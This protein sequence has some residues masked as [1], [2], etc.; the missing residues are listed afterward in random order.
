MKARIAP[1]AHAAVH[2]A[3]LAAAALAS[4]PALSACG[5]DRVP[6]QSDDG[7]G[8]G[9]D[10]DGGGDDDG[11]DDGTTTPPDMANEL[12]SFI[13]GEVRVTSYDGDADDLLTA[14]LGR[15]G[16][17]G[18]APLP[19]DP[20]SPTAAELRRLAIYSN[21]RALV[22]MSANGGYGRFWGPNVDLDGNDTLGEGKIAGTEYLAF[23][24]DGTGTRNATLLVQI[25]DSLDPDHPC[26]VTATSSGSRGVYG[27]ISAAGEWGLKRGC[28]VAYTDKGTGNGGHELMTDTVT[29]IDGALS[30]RGDAGTTSLFGAAL[31]ADELAAFNADSPYRYAYKH[32][33]SQQNPEAS[34]GLYTL[35]AVQFATWA[36]NEA[37]GA[38][39]ESGDGVAIRYPAGSVRT[40]AAAVSNGGGAALAAAELD[41]EGWIT[42]VVV[43]E[44]QINLD[45]PAGLSIEQGAAAVAAFGDPL[46][47]YVTTANLFEPCAA[48]AAAAAGA[49][50]LAAVPQATAQARCAAL[51]ADGLV[52]GADFQSQAD[53]ALARL[54]AAGFLPDSDLLHAAMWGTQA[55]PAVAVTYANAYA[56]AS[57]LDRLC[58]FTFGPTAMGTG[59][60]GVPPAAPPMPTLFGLGNGVPPTGGIDLVY[61][62][63]TSG[64]TIHSRATPDAS[65]A[66]AVCL[67]DLFTG[68]GDL[69]DRLRDGVDAVRHG[70]DLHGKPAIIV[71]GRSDALV[72]INHASR[73]YFGM[74]RMAEGA[75][76]GLSFYEIANGQHFDAFL[77]LAGFD[78]RFVPVHYYDIQALNLM[79]EH[80]ESGAPLP[81]SQVVH[82]TPR[83]GTDGAAP[84][85]TTDNLPDLQARPGVDEI[86]FSAETATVHVPD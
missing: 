28:A 64:P 1:A 61:E 37:Y 2:A 7:A 79:W 42:A 54:H 59:L 23:S 73:P 70:G 55:V 38:P 45:V 49:P 84:P 82:A 20:A 78:T 35:Q 12:P 21:Y 48:Y 85:L 63:G 6:R 36:L 72:P 75:D 30:P 86:T 27:G 24:D 51:A 52:A 62:A 17:A 68:A 44:P 34:W 71:Q 16:L 67:R 43:G 3:L 13:A 66:G 74:N 11:G 14:G 39:L 76:S 32:A 26:I 15:T 69:A 29:L 19:A 83:G 57:V 50:F 8:S 77:G 47:D 31:S 9:A 10:D 41:T 81:P 60:A 5:D 18:P 65:Y 56:K 25:P 4:A 80:L 22:D 40:I 53:D 46:Y 33:H 58:Q